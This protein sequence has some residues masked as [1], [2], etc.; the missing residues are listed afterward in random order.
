MNETTMRN[1][2]NAQEIAGALTALDVAIP[3]QLAEALTVLDAV[4][5]FAEVRSLDIA[6]EAATVTAAKVGDLIDTAIEHELRTEA[7]KR[8]VTAIEER[9]AGR[10]HRAVITSAGA[11]ID[12]LTD[13][14]TAAADAFTAAHA[15]LPAGYDADALVRAGAETVRS[16]TDA[17]TA[18]DTLT[19]LRSIRDRLVN[20]GAKAAGDNTVEIG[21]RYCTT[22]TTGAAR[23]AAD[24]MRNKTAPLGEWGSLLTTPGVTGLAWRTVADHAAYIKALPVEENRVERVHLGAGITG[25]RTV[26]A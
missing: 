10:A 24:A 8:I 1:L 5:S 20:L 26:R 16:F 14:W 13:C 12:A 21:T 17:R 19:R 6:A 15:C 3:N 11:I 22:T 4:R 18:A 2:H 25:Q 9:V 7:R 23:R